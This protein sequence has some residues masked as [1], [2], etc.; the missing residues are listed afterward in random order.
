MDNK[1]HIF[2]FK[3]NK[4]KKKLKS[5]VRENIAKDYYENLIKKSNEIIFEKKFESGKE[6]RFHIAIITN[7]FV[8]G[9][10]HY[11]DEFGR[12]IT[13]SPKIDDT[14]YIQTIKTYRVEELIYDVKN[15][16]R[17]SV[18]DFFKQYVKKDKIYMVSQLK[19]KFIL[20]NDDDYKLFSLKNSEDCDRLLEVFTTLRD[21]GSMIIVKDISTIHRKY[22]YDLLIEKGFNKKFL[23]TSYT[24]Y[25][26]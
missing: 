7:K 18:N 8:D 1:F 15:D 12:N 23:Y 16:T 26:R 11:L 10:I 21:K 5:F 20:Q 9:N 24:T 2:I 13:I 17:V 19:N 22:L 14:N 4:K 25:P 6:C 3:N